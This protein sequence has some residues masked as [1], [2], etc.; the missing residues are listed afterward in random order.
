MK[1]I[2]IALIF[3]ITTLVARSQLEVSLGATKTDLK[4]NA[5]TIGLN[6]L[7]SLDS[8]F[9]FEQ[10]IPGKKSAIVF[11]P[12]LDIQTGTEDAYSSI[13]IKATGLITKF[14]TT[15]VA[16][17]LTP[18]FNK[19]F[20][21]FPVS[22]GVESNNRFDNINGILEAGWIPYYQSYGSSYP[23]WLRKT[24]VGIFLQAGYKFNIDTSGSN[25]I[26]GEIDESEEQPDKG[27]LRVKGSGQINTGKL[28]SIGGFK[29]G[30]VG[31]GDVWFDLLNSAI[32]HKLVGEARVFLTDTQYL[33][34]FYSFGS[35]AP[36][37]NNA[38]QT[39]VGI[40]ITF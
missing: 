7:K 5:I 39:G 28:I 22:L 6:Y 25:A 40:S 17:L 4:Q 24:N 35:G 10:F 31:D 21:V 33:S 30:L 18:D 37:F 26:G 3:I 19:T 36:L 12:E 20:H 15:T 14:R 23:D 32:Y 29:I 34:F 2:L 13:N 11:T 27:I 38:K 1:K 16:G 9:G 8:V